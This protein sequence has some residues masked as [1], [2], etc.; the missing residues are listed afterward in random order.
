MYKKWARS[1]DFDINKFY[2]KA[3]RKKFSWALESKKSAPDTECDSAR[4]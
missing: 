3:L 2:S 1:I 4:R